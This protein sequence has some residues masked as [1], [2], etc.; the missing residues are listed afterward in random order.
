MA[1]EKNL[2]LKKREV[3]GTSACKQLRREGWLPGIVNSSDGGSHPIQVS[4]HDFNLLLQHH[5]SESMVLDVRIGSQKAKKAF[6]KEVQH[7]PVTDEVL[8]MD[9]MEISMTEKMRVDIPVSLLGEPVGV[10]EE[11][12]ILEHL[13]REVEIECLPDDLRETAEL[14]VSG[15]KLGETL[16]VSDIDLGPSITV[17]TEPEVAVARVSHPAAEE[18]E[19]E[20]PPEEGEAAGEEGEEREKKETEETKEENQGE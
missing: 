2:S 14:D 4:A 5:R 15:L 10:T 16:Y 17:L 9:F 18:E 11:G 8:H 3:S 1:E 19:E 20:K 13:L 6:I 12:G 7:D